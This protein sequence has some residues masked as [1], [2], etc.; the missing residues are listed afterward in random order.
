[1]L[2]SVIRWQ[3]MPLQR[4]QLFRAGTE[5]LAQV[6]LVF[7]CLSKRGIW[8]SKGMNVRSAVST[9]DASGLIGVEFLHHVSSST[10]HSVSLPAWQAEMSLFLRNFSPLSDHLS[11]HLTGLIPTKQLS[12]SLQWSF[13]NILSIMYNNRYILGEEFNLLS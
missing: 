11:Y 7:K 8:V 9:P 6:F 1:M 10:S 4:H 5:V 3:S 2:S 13:N 12:S